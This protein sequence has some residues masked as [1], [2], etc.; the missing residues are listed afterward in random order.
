MT[1]GGFGGAAPAATGGGCPSPPG[2]RRL[3]ARV[4]HVTALRHAFPGPVYAGLVGPWTAATSR[5]TGERPREGPED[6]PAPM[7]RWD[8]RYSFCQAVW[9][10]DWNDAQS[11]V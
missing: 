8:A 6:P 1:G 4:G 11:T 3:A 7:S 5:H 9:I 10:C 2:A